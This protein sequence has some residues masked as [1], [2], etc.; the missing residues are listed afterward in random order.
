MRVVKVLDQYRFAQEYG[1]GTSFETIAAFG[2]NG[3]KPHYETSNSTNV[4][5]DDS[6]TLVLD[7]GGQYLGRYNHFYLFISK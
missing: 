6:S 7:S 3:A 5:I 4:Q 2:S 1:K